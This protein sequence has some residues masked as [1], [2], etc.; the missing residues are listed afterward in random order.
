MIRASNRFDY[1]ADAHVAAF[2]QKF[3]PLKKDEDR[4]N[5][6]NRKMRSD[7]G[8]LGY[9]DAFNRKTRKFGGYRVYEFGFES[10]ADVTGRC[11]EIEHDGIVAA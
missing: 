7:F 10:M 1:F 2:A 5:R 4:R 6:E 11:A 9:I 3:S 8:C